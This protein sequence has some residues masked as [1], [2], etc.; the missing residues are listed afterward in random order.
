MSTNA[1]RSIVGV[2]LANARHGLPPLE[3]FTS[4]EGWLIELPN[5][6]VMRVQLEDGTS[7]LTSVER[8]LESA[9]LGEVVERFRIQLRLGRA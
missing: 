8:L 3:E 2:G 7:Y 4:V 9:R 1:H 6:A 5:D